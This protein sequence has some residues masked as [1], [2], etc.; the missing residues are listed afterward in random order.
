MSELDNFRKMK[1]KFFGT[2]PNSPLMPEQKDGFTGLRYFP[3][4]AD[5]KIATPLDTFAQPEDIEM[6]TSTGDIQK[7]LRWGKI[8]FEVKGEPAELTVYVSPGGH[9]YFLPF[10][11]ATTG[12]ETYAAGRYVEIEPAPDGKLIVDFNMAYNP[13]CAYNDQWSCPMVPPENRLKVAIEAGE[14]TPEG[15]WA[16]H[17]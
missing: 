3:E 8:N 1:D 6:Q 15:E 12:K 14:K 17:G 7:Y 13:Y 5:L 11:D 10:T 2:D 16:G 4:N 9:G